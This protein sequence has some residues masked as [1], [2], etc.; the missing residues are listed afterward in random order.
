MRETVSKERTCTSA[1]GSARHVR[2]GGVLALLALAKLAGAVG[3]CFWLDLAEND[4][5]PVRARAAVALGLA[6]LDLSQ[7]AGGGGLTERPGRVLL[8]Y[9]PAVLASAT[10][11]LLGLSALVSGLETSWLARGT[12]RAR[13]GHSVLLLSHAVHR[14]LAVSASVSRCGRV[15]RLTPRT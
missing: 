7:P 2:A 4:G 10:E 14:R 1:T 12:L 3:A 15:S 5:V 8:T 9:D 6:G 11:G 13:H